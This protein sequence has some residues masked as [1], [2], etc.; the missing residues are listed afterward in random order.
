MPSIIVCPNCK[1][2]T[3]K[4]QYN[5]PHC[6]FR[7]EPFLKR[8][9]LV[10]RDTFGASEINRNRDSA[11]GTVS[12][13]QPNTA[14]PI[15]VAIA[16]AVAWAIVSWL[17]ILIAKPYGRYISDSEMTEALL[18]TVIPALG[19]FLVVFL[20]KKKGSHSDS[21]VGSAISGA[22]V[23]AFN[24]WSK[25]KQQQELE[26]F[27]QSLE[28]MDGEELGLPVALAANFKNTIR[29]EGIDLSDPALLVL[30][31]PEVIF[32]LSKRVTPLQRQ[33]RNHD[34]LPI[35]IWVHSLR[36]VA[37][38]ELRGL[39][40]KMWGQLERGF[41]YVEEAADSYLLLTGITLDTLGAEEFP[42][43]LTP[44]PID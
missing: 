28:A 11:L 14:S 5:C 17:F 21:F 40:R 32:E 9:D 34:A 15:G 20:L 4:E 23:G 41:K 22:A 25:E 30:A 2:E 19:I 33:G 43:G 37:R 18:W 26:E 35:I 3:Y 7:G 8:E 38:P 16:V 1:R 27:V 42:T 24:R 36:A 31:N 39:G 12:T 44:K 29:K 10:S 13:N 6:S